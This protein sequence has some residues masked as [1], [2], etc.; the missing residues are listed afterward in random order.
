MTAIPHHDT[1]NDE[2][3]PA[4]DCGWAVTESKAGTLTQCVGV[5]KQLT[6]SPVVK[7]ISRSRGIRKW[8]EPALFRRSEREPVVLVSCGFRSEKAT[9][10]IK[11]AYGGRPLAVHLQR[12]RIDGYDM[13]FVSRH[14]WVPELDN[15]PNYHPMVG[16]PH[17]ITSKRLS[18]LREDARARYG[19]GGKP[20]AAVFVG[21]PNGAYLYD[22]KTHDVISQAVRHLEL[23][24]WHVL[25]SVS[26]RSE[27]ATLKALLKLRSPNVDVWD[28]T[29]ENPYL[30]YMAAADGFLITK[31]SITMPCEA[32]ATGKPVYSLELTHVPGPRLE[33]FEFYHRD[34]SK[35]LGLTRPYHGQMEAYTYQPL[36]ETRRIGSIIRSVLN[37]DP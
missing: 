25:V 33:K 1:S 19:S 30:S 35:T 9:L 24:G 11:S 5:L 7:T 31:D 3:I 17:Q 4:A 16:V 15:L 22:E 28:R 21:G 8:F 2:A 13:V 32:V 20:I 23:E 27:E 34:L 6:P 36:D 18:P 10:D 37:P 12:P 26:R 14:D 29:G